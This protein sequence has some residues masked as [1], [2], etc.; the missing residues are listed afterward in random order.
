MGARYEQKMIILPDGL[1]ILLALCFENADY[2]NGF[3]KRSVKDKI[4]KEQGFSMGRAFLEHKMIIVFSSISLLA[5]NCIIF[6]K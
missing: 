3:S 4:S 2:G 5:E 6:I 1:Y